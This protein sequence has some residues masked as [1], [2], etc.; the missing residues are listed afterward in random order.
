MSLALHG[1]TFRYDRHGPDVLQDV[2]LQVAPGRVVG[3]MAPSGGGKS[4]LL[5]IAALLLTPS[6]GEVSVCGQPVTATGYRVPA[7]LR[8][9]TSLVAQSPRAA[10]N[11]RFTLR[12]IVAEPLCSAA[13]QLRVDPRRHEERIA[14]LADRV[15]LSADLLDRHPHQVS[16]GQLQRAALARALALRPALLLCDEPTA[17]LDAPTTA[18][19]MR[20]LSDEAGSGAAVLIAAHDR[21]L[22]TAVADEVLELGNH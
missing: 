22:L 20:A 1:V 8:R 16:D 6:A 7:V 10:T 4:T 14:E 21:P 13:G 19:I 9:R 17:M 5:R 15:R 2:N 18:V 12:H 11:P 3:L